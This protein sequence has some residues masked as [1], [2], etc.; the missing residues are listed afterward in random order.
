MRPSPFG[1][2]AGEEGLQIDAAPPTA[3]SPTLFQREREF[4]SLSALFLSPQD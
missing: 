3:L 2:R 1:R 4:K